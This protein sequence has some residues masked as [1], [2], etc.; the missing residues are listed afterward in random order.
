MINGEGLSYRKNSMIKKL[1]RQ[2]IKKLSLIGCLLNLPLLTATSLR[3]LFFKDIVDNP[4]SKRVLIVFYKTGGIHDV[5]AALN[6]NTNLKVVYCE[7]SNLQSINRFFFKKHLS[8]FLQYKKDPKYSENFENCKNFFSKILDTNFFYK[9]EIFFLSF[10]IAYTEDRVLKQ[11]CKEKKIKFLVLHKESVLSKGQREV[12]TNKYIEILKPINNV[13]KVAVYNEDAK[14]VLYQNKILDKKKIYV[15][16]CAR[17]G[18]YTSL[19]KKHKRKIKNILFFLIQD[20]AGIP[21]D[22]KKKH[23]KG[24]SIK[25]HKPFNWN[26]LS[27]EVTETMIKLAK[28]NSGINFIFKGKLSFGNKLINIL[29]KRKLPRNIY[30]QKGGTA[31]NYINQSDLIIGFNTSAVME[32]MIAKKYVIIPFYK[33]YRKMPFLHYVH[34]YDKNYLVNNNIH[35][36]KKIQRLIDKNQL[37]FPNPQILPLKNINKYFG[38]IHYSK[39]KLKKFLEK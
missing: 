15:T 1:L 33:K 2:F 27:K 32:A 13:T 16:G 5:R 37:V 8:A 26:L 28:R 7:R 19:N 18:Q 12:F 14:K 29:T 22:F 20:T 30:L 31:V 21:F 11:A 3:L 17:A 9:K 35:L 6:N 36:E 4:N 34:N 25:N 24:L 39:K 10:N 23:M 38:D